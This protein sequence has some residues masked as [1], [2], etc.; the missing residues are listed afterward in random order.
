MTRSPLKLR[1]LFLGVTALLFAWVVWEAGGFPERA[2][3]FP[4]TVALLGLGVVLLKMALLIRKDDQ[5]PEEPPV[6]GDHDPEPSLT[7]GE[8]WRR[9]LPFLGA[10]ALYGVGIALLGFYPASLLFVVLFLRAF[11]D[12]GWVR[13]V[14]SGVVFTLILLA[15]G[16]VLGLELPGGV[17]GLG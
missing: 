12:A 16:A 7:I 8:E 14:M 6:A 9:G 10:F 2:R 13:A 17:V 1:L 5:D 15:L 4:R 3:V 11:D